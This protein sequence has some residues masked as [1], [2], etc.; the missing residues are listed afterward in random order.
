MGMVVEN[1]GEQARGVPKTF[2]FA[3]TPDS[4]TVNNYSATVW[5]N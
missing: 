3:A 4:M 1:T 5:I 2:Y